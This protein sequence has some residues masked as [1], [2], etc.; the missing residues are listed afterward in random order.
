MKSVVHRNTTQCR[1]S[2]LSLVL[3]DSLISS[4]KIGRFKKTATLF[5]KNM[6]SIGRGPIL[7]VMGIRRISAHF[8]RA[9]HD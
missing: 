9:A 4:L 3:G 8:N 5:A 6:K 2:A 7:P 1:F